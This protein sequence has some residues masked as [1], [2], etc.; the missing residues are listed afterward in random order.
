MTGA[1]IPNISYVSHLTFIAVANPFN[2][3][4]TIVF[5]PVYLLSIVLSQSFELLTLVLLYIVQHLID[6]FRSRC[7][8]YASTAQ[9]PLN[10][11]ASVKYPGKHKKLR[12][13]INGIVG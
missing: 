8:A 2:L 3:L 5:N 9:A 4:G 12:E 6:L 1:V 10:T 13:D 7:Y 11:S